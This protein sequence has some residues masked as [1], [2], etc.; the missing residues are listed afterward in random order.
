[1]KYEKDRDSSDTPCLLQRVNKMYYWIQLNLE[2]SCGNFYDN[3]MGRRSNFR[4]N[5][6]V[7]TI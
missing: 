1:M 5:S 7:Y 3:S 4:S 2:K 6:V